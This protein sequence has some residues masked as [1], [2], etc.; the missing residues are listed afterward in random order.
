MKHGG[1]HV[2]LENN[3]LHLCQPVIENLKNLPTVKNILHDTMKKE[4]E[5]EG[6]KRKEK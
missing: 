3:L 4:E 5:K 2:A 6:V 1:L